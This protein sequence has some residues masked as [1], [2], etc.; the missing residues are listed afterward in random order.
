MSDDAIDRDRLNLQA[1]I[2]RIDRDITESRRAREE[3]FKLMDER[4]MLEAQTSKIERDRW[5]AP[6]GALGLGLGA[7]LAAF[8]VLIALARSRGVHV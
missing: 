7:A 2:A 1:T 3:A 5:L 8:T 6:A 4:K